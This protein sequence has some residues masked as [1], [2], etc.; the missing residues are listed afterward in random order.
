MSFFRTI[1]IFLFLSTISLK[2]NEVTVIELHKQINLDQL[3]LE[4]EN[5][6]I[7][8]SVVDKLNEDVS[9]NET[10]MEIEEKTNESSKENEDQVNLENLSNDETIRVIKSETI[11]DLQE[12]IIDNH[13]ESI[14]DIKSE[15]LH[16][17]FIKI[18]SN[19]ELDNQNNINNKLYFI[20]KKL[21]EIGEIGKAYKLIKSIDIDNISNKDFLSYYYLVE[22]N[23]LFSTFNL[24]EVCELK[25]IL[26]NKSIVLSK[27]LLE[28]TDIFCLTLQNELAEAKLLNSLL[29][30]SEK[31]IDQNFQNLFNYMILVDND[32]QVFQQLNE[33][34]S[35]ELI[36]LYS[37]M[38]RINELALDEDFIEIDPLNLSI[39]V[40]LSESSKMEIRIKAANRAFYDEVLSI[41]SISA[42]YQSVDFNSKEFNNP[43]QTILSLNGNEELIMAFYYQLANIQIFPDQRLNV[44]LDY[45]KFAKSIG[46]EKIAYAITRNIIE[47]FT[48]TSEN[49]KFGMD[50]ALAHISN[51]NYSEALKWINL[52]ENSNDKYE[53]IEYA[54]F[55]IELNQTNNLDTVIEYLSN[56]YSNIANLNNQKNYET[57]AVLINFLN[58][59]DIQQLEFP[60][61]EII[62]ERPMP[63]YFL[64]KDIK[65]NI[66]SQKDL[67][68]FILSLISIN[69]KKLSQL[70]PEHLNLVLKAYSVYDG[71][72]LIKPIILEILNDLEI[73]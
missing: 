27:F 72:S 61:T 46:L 20:V 58:I 32:D 31:E 51:E 50:V 4:S 45:W 35:K 26:L 52:Y 18:L 56:N 64:I 44:V 22:L 70:H 23:Y 67:S 13:F 24:S 2:A 7:D 16:R 36:F 55:L 42:L 34:K 43:E 1:I 40:I 54:K 71:G 21:Y 59:E 15:T 19:I 39:P 3:V 41:D 69:N 11:F 49:T 17:E 9:E 38:L 73:F 6:L 57:F 33:I 48:P 66:E 68:I 10:L 30:E 12:N 47:T 37:A 63:S 14:N 62:D 8:E 25:S 65:T 28:K 53:Q 5:Q 60:F 29:L